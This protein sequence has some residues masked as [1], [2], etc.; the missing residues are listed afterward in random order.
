MNLTWRKDHS[1][2][3]R[4]LL[5]FGNEERVHDSL[6]ATNSVRGEVVDQP[7]DSL[8]GIRVETISVSGWIFRYEGKINMVWVIEF[9]VVRQ[10]WDDNMV[11]VIQFLPSMVAA[12]VTF[13]SDSFLTNR[14]ES[15]TF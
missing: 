6:E 14:S 9:G 12:S 11:W 8:K 2:L 7:E 15:Q 1:H 3:I 10:F 13:L 4:G 5:R